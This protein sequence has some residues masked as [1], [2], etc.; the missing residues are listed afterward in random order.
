MKGVIWKYQATPDDPELKDGMRRMGCRVLNPDPDFWENRFPVWAICGSLVRRTLAKGDVLVFT[1]IASACHAARVARYLC[2]G[3]LTVKEILPNDKALLRDRRF[4]ARYRR[5][6]RMDLR[7][8]LADDEEST[9]KQRP[10]CI[11][12]GDP[13]RS[14]WFGRNGPN[15]SSVV[16]AAKI[17]NLNLDSRRIRDLTNDETQALFS[18]LRAW[19][20][21]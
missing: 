8:H 16:N 21:D 10:Q 1:P 7:D 15:L 5:N 2:T 17:R 4:T 13:H 14:Q 20:S 19:P 18:R 6:Y 12:V 3:Y 9:R 11:I